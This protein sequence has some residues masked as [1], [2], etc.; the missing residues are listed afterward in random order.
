MAARG[1]LKPTVRVSQ[2]LRE[3]EGWNILM[4]V[5]DEV[6]WLESEETV[7]T[8]TYTQMAVKRER[9]EPVDGRGLVKDRRMGGLGCAEGGPGGDE[10]VDVNGGAFDG[11]DD[12]DMLM[13]GE[14][15]RDGPGELGGGS[16]GKRKGDDRD[17]QLD[18]D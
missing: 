9:E 11:G 13:P 17:D 3:L 1:G 7:A 8:E 12:A 15:L 4:L 10:V 6:H 5:D 18:G 14:P 16:T 2:A